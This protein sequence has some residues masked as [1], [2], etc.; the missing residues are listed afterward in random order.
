MPR[1][2][3]VKRR[4]RPA[5]EARE[6]DTP[7][8][9]LAPARKRAQAA[10]KGTQAATAKAEEQVRDAAP[11]EPPSK[12]ARQQ[13]DA[14]RVPDEIRSRFI[15]IGAN[16]YFPDGAPAFTDHGGKLTTTSENTEVIRSLVTIAKARGWEDIRVT[17]TERFRK[18]AWFAARVAGLAV[19]GYRPTEFEQAHIVRAIARRAAGPTP[20]AGGGETE[21]SAS[22][23][24]RGGTDDAPRA[25]DK[26]TSS[27]TGRLVD[28]GRA[29]YRHDPKAPMSYFVRLET[30]R[31]DREVWGVDLE[32]A[33]RE[34]LTR[35]T[36]GDEVTVRS[37]AREPVTVNAP[38]RDAEGRIVGHREI[39]AHRNR[40]IVERS[41]FLAERAAAAQVFRD[42]AIKASEA[43]KRH[44]ELR[45]SY[46]QLQVAK[47]GAEREIRHPEDRARFVER[48]RAALADAIERGEPLEPV[49]LKERRAERAHAR[50]PLP[51]R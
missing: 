28:H 43:V 27:I 35:P 31:G 9:T 5:A 15:G 40:W 36:M 7:L 17:G 2:R 8:N 47:A 21:R 34:S 41:D 24:G 46:L 3:E 29:T 39:E 42:P 6:A 37:Y 14:R 22:T 33:F 19:R 4:P 18:E 48:A 23:R 45:G 44:P 11:R 13:P 16:Y 20:Q 51:A 12:P 32:R 50:D 30:E 26:D 10:S 49:R 25:V 1:T 38:R